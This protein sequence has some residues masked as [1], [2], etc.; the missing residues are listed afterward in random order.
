[1]DDGDA[2]VFVGSGKECFVEKYC[3]FFQNLNDRCCE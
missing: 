1:V 2:A 3:R